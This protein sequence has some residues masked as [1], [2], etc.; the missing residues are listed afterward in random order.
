MRG[1]GAGRP[2]P[3]SPSTRFLAGLDVSSIQLQMKKIHRRIPGLLGVFVLAGGCASSPKPATN[4]V[5][6]A[7]ERMVSGCQYLGD[8]TGSSMVP[9]PSYIDRCKEDAL[10]KA[11]ELGATH[12]LWTS[13]QMGA[14][15]KAYK[16][17]AAPVAAPAPADAAAPSETPSAESAGTPAAEAAE[18]GP[19]ESRLTKTVRQGDRR[20]IDSASSACARDSDHSWANN[21]RPADR[22]SCRS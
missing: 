5:L 6:Q 2:M 12:L 20:S 11:G 14:S 18:A 15:G 16:C 1:R 4:N 10:E 19:G 13:V 21:P 9:G 22:R 7:D 3:T 8:V 17:V